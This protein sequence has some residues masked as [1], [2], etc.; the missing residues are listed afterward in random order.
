MEELDQKEVSNSTG[1]E[2]L[3]IPK[4]K[5]RIERRKKF[6]TNADLSPPRDINGNEIFWD[7]P[8]PDYPGYKVSQFGTILGKNGQTLSEAPNECGYVRKNLRGDNKSKC[9]LV[10]VI[11]ALT[12]LILDFDWYKRNK[13]YIYIDHI[14]RIRNQ[15]DIFNLRVCTPTENNL[16]KEN[17][18]VSRPVIYTSNGITRRWKSVA[19]ASRE[20]G[21]SYGSVLYACHNGAEYEG[22]AFNFETPT[23][24]KD[25][26]LKIYSKNKNGK[27][28]VQMDMYNKTIKIWPSISLAAKEYSAGGFSPGLNAVING[29]RLT[30]TIYGYRWRFATDDEIDEYLYQAPPPSQLYGEWKVLRIEGT[31]IHASSKG[32]ILHTNGIPTK[33]IVRD[34]GYMYTLVIRKKYGVHRLILMAFFPCDNMDDL[35]V[36]HRDGNRSNNNLENLFWVTNEKNIQLAHGIVV[37]QYSADGETLIRQ[38]GSYAEAARNFGDTRGDAI[39]SA[40]KTGTTAY[41]YTWKTPDES[42]E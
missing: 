7:F 40:V 31:I 14:N 3:V 16:N 25:M 12:F 6:R 32:Y 15:N 22:Y 27:P 28:I 38:F 4:I 26:S 20:T 23:E 41:G 24:V 17:D 33:G 2:S 10:Q 8:H 18:G 35:V 36:D 29:K 19:E 5:I 9:F 39:S 11:M 30:N 34:D 42:K 37:N 1:G 13:K 21:I